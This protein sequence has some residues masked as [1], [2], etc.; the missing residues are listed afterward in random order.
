VPLGDQIERDLKEAMKAGERLR[1]ET[2]RMA[3]SALKYRQIEKG[4]PL[5]DEDALSVLTTLVKQRRDSADQYRKAGRE[6]LA[7]KEEEEIG[8]LRAYMPKELSPEEL[9]SLIALAIEEAG[10][11]GPQDMGKVMKLL[12]PKVKGA[13]DGKLVNEKVKE[14]LSGIRQP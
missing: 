11:R 4:A 9:S 8:F 10:A 5:V 7:Q 14:A 3:K 13:V 6:D 2:L 1:L 12:M